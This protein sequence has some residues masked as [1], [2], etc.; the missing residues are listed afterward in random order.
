MVNV[1]AGLVVLGA[2]LGRTITGEFAA[3]DHDSLTA[4]AIFWQFV[5][6]AGLVAY[7]VLFLHP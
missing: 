3:D 1:I 7:S 6:V 2:V 5:N 4:A